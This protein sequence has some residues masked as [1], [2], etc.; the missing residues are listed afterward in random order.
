MKRFE[1]YPIWIIILFNLVSWSV[2]AAGIYLLY[3]IRPWLSLLFLIY[4]LYLEF[5][6]YKEG[7]V[8]CYYYGKSCASGRGK[9]AKIFK[10]GDPKKFCEKSVSFKD[11]LPSLIPSIAPVI[12]G[13][14][15]MI[16]NFNWIILVLTIW[17]VI[18]WF[19]G[20]PIVY[21]QLACPHCKQDKIC[22]PVSKYF[23]EMEKSKRK[24][25][26]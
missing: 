25:K 14:Y 5:K 20:N 13:I 2:Y 4:I 6:V 9:I 17:P 26:H 19:V 21:G 16:V 8:N 24:K 7:C 22:C 10:K 23:R 11:F 18:V 1:N 15:L 3:L 12:A